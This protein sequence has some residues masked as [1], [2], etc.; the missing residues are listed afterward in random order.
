V[1]TNPEEEAVEVEEVE[2]EEHA[3]ATMATVSRPAAANLT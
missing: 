2:V 3:A 1:T